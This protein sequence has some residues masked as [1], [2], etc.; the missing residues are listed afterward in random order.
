[1][2]S[3]AAKIKYHELV[4]DRP[5]VK[6]L[7]QHVDFKDVYR[8]LRYHYADVPA[9][10]K[11]DYKHVYQAIKE[12]PEL[13]MPGMELVITTGGRFIGEDNS[14][15]CQSEEDLEGWYDVSSTNDSDPGVSYAVD[16]MP[17]DQVANMIVSKDTLEHY[18]VTD[19]IAHILWE[20]TFYGF[21]QEEVT[22]HGDEVFSRVED[23]IKD[24]NIKELDSKALG[25]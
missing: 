7:I 6:A 19:I 11:D 4:I 2:K 8:S 21:T 5:T 25:D 24:K 15:G 22:D 14:V 23:A 18:P 9:E 20:V 10:S 13:D 16:F 17:W 3:E 1:M 12:S